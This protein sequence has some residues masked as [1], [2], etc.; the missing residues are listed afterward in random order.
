MDLATRTYHAFRST[1]SA[2][3]ALSEDEKVAVE[4]FDQFLSPHVDAYFHQC[5]MGQDC[6]KPR[7]GDNPRNT[8]EGEKCDIDDNSRDDNVISI[9]HFANIDIQ[10]GNDCPRL[11]AQEH[12]SGDVLKHNS[13]LL[14]HN[15]LHYWEMKQSMKE[16][17]I[18]CLFEMNKVHTL[19]WLYIVAN[20]TCSSFVYGS[21]VSVPVI[22]AMS[23]CIRCSIF[24]LTSLQ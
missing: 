2:F 22:M 17:D 4:Y 13:I 6:D 8:D 12:T 1:H 9:A 5:D 11:A 20:R 10:F 14:W 24:G 19:T 23:C 16:G 18:G 15:L 7:T 21:S 3:M